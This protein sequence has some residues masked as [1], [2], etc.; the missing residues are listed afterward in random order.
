MRV[1]AGKARS[2][3]LKTIEGMN[4]RPTTDRIKET[5]FNMIQPSIAD[6]RFLDLFAGSGGIG[7]EALSRGAREAVFVENNPKAMMCVKD[8][9]KFTKL[10]G[11]AVTLTTD[12]MNALYKLE[13]EKIIVS[14]RHHVYWVEK[15]D[16][17]KQFRNFKQLAKIYSKH[18]A[19]VEKYIEDNKVNFEDVD[20]I[21]K[22]CS[23]ADSL[24]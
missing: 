15:D 19:E 8:N 17:M 20:Q 2:L 24:K 18:R 6:S 13:G 10:E 12:V 5:L 11:K 23:Y 7:I 21:V 22:L 1:I 16:K 9:L 4:T 3:R 14:N